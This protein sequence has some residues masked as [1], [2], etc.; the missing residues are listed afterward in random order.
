[1]ITDK[2]IKTY[3]TQIKNFLPIY[4]KKEIRY[5]KDLTDC[6]T[7]FAANNPN[8]TI[9]DIIEQ[10]GSPLELVYNYMETYDTEQL[11]KKLSIRRTIKR[12]VVIFIILS[13]IALCTYTIFLYKAYKINNETVIT[14]T[15]TVIKD[16]DN[17]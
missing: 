13:F 10:H 12:I 5:I 3:V 2:E 4:S 1:M 8:S 6:L 15:E 7:E 11:I 9:E 14:E 16:E 17:P